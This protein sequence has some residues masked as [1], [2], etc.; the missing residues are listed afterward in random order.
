MFF[1]V[2]GQPSL[3]SGCENLGGTYLTR[4]IEEVYSSKTLKLGYQITRCSNANRP[5][6]MY[7]N[8]QRE[9][10]NIIRNKILL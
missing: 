7:P 2:T 1:F 5:Q 6:I 9:K 3:L 8:Q 4:K 10:L